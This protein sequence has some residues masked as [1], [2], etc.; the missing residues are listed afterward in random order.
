MH[1]AVGMGCA[2]LMSLA[3][4]TIFRRGWRWLPAAMTF[5]GLWAL[6]PDLPRIFR[7]DLPLTP[8]SGLL[9]SKPLE[10][11]LHGWGNLFFFHTRLDLQPNEYALH[12]LLAIIVLYNLSLL[13]LMWLPR[14]RGY[15]PGHVPTHH[16]PHA[17]QPA[18]RHG[19]TV[20][21]TPHAS[22]PR[23]PRSSHLARWA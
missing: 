16:E 12:G 15:A 2:G 7:E 10:V 1:F 14:R 3:A 13:L 6:A 19:R 17:M 21:M 20:A 18:H 22:P 11:W 23:M 4:C 8:L 9:G 5:G